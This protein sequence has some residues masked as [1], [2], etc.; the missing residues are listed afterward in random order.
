MSV[1]DV[2][3][4]VPAIAPKPST[5]GRPIDRAV[6]LQHVDAPN[7]DRIETFGIAPAEPAR[8]C[9]A[10][11]PYRSFLLETTASG[12]WMPSPRL[13]AFDIVLPEF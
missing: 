13:A 9:L 7:V 8:L 1:C 5:I 6:D 3:I 2:R 4:F 11:V 12:C 10:V